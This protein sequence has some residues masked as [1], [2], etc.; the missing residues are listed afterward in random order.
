LKALKPASVKG[1][2]ECSS[3]AAKDVVGRPAAARMRS[4]R[5]KPSA[6]GTGRWKRTRSSLNPG[7]AA[8]P[9][10]YWKT[11]GM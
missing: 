4:M 6:S 9:P 10:E 3:Q 2:G 5:A 11:P 8:T 7:S 1:A